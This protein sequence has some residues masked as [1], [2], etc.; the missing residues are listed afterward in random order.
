MQAVRLENTEK[1]ITSKLLCILYYNDVTSY[2]YFPT[3]DEIQVMK[4]LVDLS[5]KEHSHFV[6]GSKVT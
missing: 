2:P 4:L 1:C 5:H 3:I 6:C